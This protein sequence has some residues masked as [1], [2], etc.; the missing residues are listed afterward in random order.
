ML[1][2]WKMV[3]DLHAEIGT[4]D[5]AEVVMLFLSEVEEVLYGTAPD[6]M[7][8]EELHFLKGSALNLGFVALVTCCRTGERVANGGRAP[9]C[10]EQL[11]DTFARSKEEFLTGVAQYLPSDPLRSE[12]RP[13][14]HLR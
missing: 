8:N 13:A 12:T 10:L 3:E 11:Q 1:I 14:L 7:R 5:F 9:I 4:D 2:D 6:Q